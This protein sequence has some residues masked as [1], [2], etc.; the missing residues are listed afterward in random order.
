FD[1]HIEVPAVSAQDLTLPP[2]SENSQDVA[3]RVMAARAIQTAR[4]QAMGIGGRVRCNADVDGEALE[5]VAA[6]D[7]P[8]KEILSEAIEMMR[9]T[10]RGYHRILRV[11]RTLADLDG[12]DNISK[13]HTSEAL[14]YRQRKH[15][16]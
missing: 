3:A 7:K 4:Y 9:L 2:P 15:I 10:A 11:A 6:L 12:L 5:E 13:I 1:I 8:G 14:S 16:R